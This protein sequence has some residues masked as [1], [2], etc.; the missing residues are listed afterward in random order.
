M[1]TEIATRPQMSNY[2]APRIEEGLRALAMVSGNCE[3]ASRLTGI[4]PKTLRNWRNDQHTERYAAIQ[5]EL[6]PTIL[7]DIAEHSEQLAR[8]AAELEGELIEDLAA[9]KGKLTPNETAGALRN[10]STAKAI[11]V[12]KA[13]LLRGRP[14]SITA[15]ADVTELLKGLSSRFGAVVSTASELMPAQSRQAETASKNTRDA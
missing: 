1:S 7:A 8:R 4:P 2:T 6:Q 11:N 9:N 5:A 12:D 15:T 13:L 14:T 10:V 3:K